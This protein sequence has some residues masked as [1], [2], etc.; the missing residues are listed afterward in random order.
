TVYTDNNWRGMSRTFDESVSCMPADLNDK[1]S[2]MRVER[3]NGYNSSASSGS[4]RD[5]ITLYV[6]CNYRGGSHQLRPGT[7][8]ANQLG[9]G[10]DRLSAIRIPKGMKV[11]V[12]MDNNFRGAS[13]IY[14]RDVS[15][16]PPVYNDKVSSIRVESTHSGGNYNSNSNRYN[17][18]RNQGLSGNYDARGK[19]PC[20]LGR[21]APTSNCDFGVVRRG[22]GDADVQIRM[23]N[24][25]LR[26]IYFQNGRAV[27]YD[28]SQGGGTFRA[29]KEVDLY[30]INIGDERYEIPEAVIYG[31]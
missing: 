7:Y 24:G 11:T 12:Y 28:R 10:N 16:L 9:I 22:N 29:S 6:D 4:S 18:N 21:G 19:V 1:I 3:T 8:T 25:K 13:A 5:M 15:C 2:S 20:K 31:G 17:N 14:T 23:P 26:F 27:G 30:I